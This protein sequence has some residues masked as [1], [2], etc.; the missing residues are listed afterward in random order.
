MVT[1]KVPLWIHLSSL[2]R[3]C[4]TITALA[5]GGKLSSAVTVWIHV[6]QTSKLAHTS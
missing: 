6:E 1:V 2:R 4:G 5:A 3:F